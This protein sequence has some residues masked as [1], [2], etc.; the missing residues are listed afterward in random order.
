M[1]QH[2]AWDDLPDPWEGN[3]NIEY[4]VWHEDRLIPATPQELACIKE[5]ERTRD[6]LWRLEHMHERERREADRMQRRLAALGAWCVGR[7][8]QTVR[9]LRH[10]RRHGQPLHQ[11]GAHVERPSMR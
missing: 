5:D 9:W 1:Y 8:R 10:R 7:V 6:A 4:W 3:H 11:E 2:E